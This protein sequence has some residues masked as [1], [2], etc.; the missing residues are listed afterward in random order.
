MKEN[1]SIPKMGESVESGIVAAWFKADGETVQEGDEL[2]EL[3]TDKATLAVPSTFS[4][5]LRHLAA[6]GDEVEIGQVVA[7]IDSSG[8]PTLEALVWTNDTTRATA[9]VRQDGVWSKTGA[10]TRRYLGTV[11]VDGES[12]M[13]LV[14]VFPVRIRLENFAEFGGRVGE[15]VGSKEGAGERLADKQGIGLRLNGAPKGFDGPC[16]IACA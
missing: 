8:T 3:E 12:E 16:R 2:F 13:D 9:L 14:G 11:R 5:V 10:L 7:E 4:G 6:E 1:V 15:T